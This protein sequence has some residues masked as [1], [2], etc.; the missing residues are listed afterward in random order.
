MRGSRPFQV[1]PSERFK[2]EETQDKGR[3]KNHAKSCF[4]VKNLISTS[5]RRAEH[6]FAGQN[7]QQADIKKR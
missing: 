1:G 4:S 3:I 6:L 7:T 5:E 2:G